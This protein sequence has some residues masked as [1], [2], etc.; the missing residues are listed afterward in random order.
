MCISN[1]YAQNDVAEKPSDWSFF[2]Y[3]TPDYG[4]H[5]LDV[6]NRGTAIPAILKVKNLLGYGM[7]FQANYIAQGGFILS[8][9]MG[10]QYSP[11]HITLNGSSNQF[12][13]DSN[14]PIYRDIKFEGFSSYL[15]VI[16]G[17]SL[18]LNNNKGAIN[19]AAGPLLSL[20]FNG[21]HKN[22]MIFD[23]DNNGYVNPILYY[24]LHLG[25]SNSPLA[26]GLDYQVYFWDR[27]NIILKGTKCLLGI[28]CRQYFSGNNSEVR[29]YGPDR[30]SLGKTFLHS[31]DLSVS[32]M[33]GIQF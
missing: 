11:E 28:E 22:E 21:Y 27:N 30:T 17:Y 8:M 5:S 19:F 7:H 9:G 14:T 26:G 15:K 32:L 13:F 10:Y 3:G 4:I 6:Q 18:K 25:S 24:S 1:V 2:I 33:L 29:Y 16:F 31:N 20:I 23:T 12:G